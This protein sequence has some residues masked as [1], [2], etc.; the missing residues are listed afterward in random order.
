VT[1]LYL[2]LFCCIYIYCANTV[3]GST[4]TSHNYYYD[5]VNR[6]IQATLE[7]GSMWKYTYNNRNELTG[8][9]RYWSDWAPVTGQQYGYGFDNIGNRTNSTVGSIGNAPSTT[10]VVNNLDEYTNIATPGYKDIIGDAIATNYVTVNGGTADRKAEYFHKQ[11]AITNTGGPVWQEVTNTS[12]GASITGGLAFPGSSQAMTYDADGNLTFD[13]IWTYS[14][15]AQN[16]LILMTMTN[17]AGIAPTNRLQLAFAYDYMSRRISKVV[18]TNSTGNSFTPQSTNYFIYDGWNLIATFGAANI[19]QQSFVWGLDLSRNM[20]NA[21]GIGGLLALSN[22]GT[23]YFASYDGNGNITGLIN[24]LNES[25]SGRYEYSPFGEIIRA[26]GPMAKANPYRFSTKFRDDESGLVYY[27]YR[28]Y[29]PMQGRWI[30]RDSSG[31]KS[32]LCL[33][34]FCHNNAIYR[35]DVDGRADWLLI[36]EGLANIAVGGAE[37]F[38]LGETEV[39]TGGLATAFVV[40]GVTGCGLQLGAGLNQLFDGITAGGGFS[41]TTSPNAMRDMGLPTNVGQALGSI[42]GSKAGAMGS[43]LDTSFENIA[44]A[45]MMPGGGLLSKV[46]TLEFAESFTDMATDAYSNAKDQSEP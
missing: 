13:G 39:G 35:F 37:L 42:F 34:L 30:G 38:L 26:T 20:T 14:W 9:G 7:D 3:N 2:H 40:T 8:A 23:N 17:I 33:F 19:I 31:E 16:R 11:I 45:A 4:F 32:A 6:R 43:Y 15:D 25:V 18:S 29:N 46:L 10:Y 28:Y 41:P 36:G 24:G 5:D 44:A 12:G 1:L 22:T 27:G 21:G